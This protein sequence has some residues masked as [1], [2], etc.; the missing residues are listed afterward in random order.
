MDIDEPAPSTRASQDGQVPAS[1]S[2]FDWLKRQPA[3]FQDEALGPA[4]EA[5]PRWR[6]GH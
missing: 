5:V 4:G 6:P 3:A 1:L 2:Y